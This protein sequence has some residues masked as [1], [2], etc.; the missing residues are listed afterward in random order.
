VERGGQRHERGDLASG[1]VV[2][3]AQGEE[4]LVAWA[5]GRNRRV[6]L[7]EDLRSF[8]LLIGRGSTAREPVQNLGI[9]DQLDQAAGRGGAARFRPGRPAVLAAVVVETEPAHDHHEPGGELAPSISS[10]GS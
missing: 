7:L 5:Q 4:Q 8:Q 3:V 2:L 6:E 9:E 10:E 1:A